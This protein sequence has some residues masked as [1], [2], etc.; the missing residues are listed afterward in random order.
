LGRATAVSSSSR[1]SSGGGG[2][3]GG[4]SS[5]SSGAK[6]ADLGSTASMIPGGGSGGGGGGSDFSLILQKLV[7]PGS[8]VKKGD[9][10]A[11]FDR[12]YMLLRLDDYRASVKQQ[13]LDMT[14]LQA[15]L[16]VS[17]KSRQQK[18][19]AAKGAVDKAKLDLNTT[20]VR[21][22]IDSVKL[23]L[24]LEEAEAN[25]KQVMDQQ[26]FA[27]ISEVAAI[28][29]EAL[30]HDRADLEL[31]RATMNAD[32]MVSK[33][34]MEG[35]VVMQNF[36]SGTE[37]RQIQ[38]GDQIYPGQF[39]MQVVDLRSMVVNATV[40]QADVEMLKIGAKAH[41]RFDA[42]PDL[43]LPA[44]VYSI[45]AM[46]KGGGMRAP[47]VKEIPV[48]LKIDRLDPRVIPD[49]SVGVDVI[50][51]SDQQAAAIAPLQSIFRDG[52]GENS[53]PYVFVQTPSG[54]QRRDVELGLANAIRVVVRSGLK[55]G[56][57]IAENRPPVMK[58]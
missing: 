5:S 3:S 12:Q 20:P 35:L 49:L 47:F 11:E 18:I 22:E 21:S 43:E 26:E 45:G 36:F 30:D 4:S 37:M 1:V 29:I 55:P 25:L 28:R 2:S 41:V 54:W 56:E 44:H 42:Y 24:A 19:T 38:Q 15:N 9:E 17:R 16:E 53:Q 46:T 34:S 58:Q 31:K 13:D 50:A 23:K 8:M 33:A 57:V 48:K 51:E 40:N 32:K 39:F 6:A 27:D 10:L 14:V 7:K 52:G